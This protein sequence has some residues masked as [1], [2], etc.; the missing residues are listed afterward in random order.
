MKTCYYVVLY[1]PRGS[2]TWTPLT[3]DDGP[4]NFFASAEL[5]KMRIKALVAVVHT[6]YLP[7]QDKSVVTEFAVGRVVLDEEKEEG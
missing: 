1:R 6:T 7:G 4:G 5:A 2:K 3:M